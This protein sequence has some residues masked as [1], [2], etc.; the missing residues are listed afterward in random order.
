MRKMAQHGLREDF[1]S[2]KN[3]TMESDEAQ[4]GPW[5]QSMRELEAKAE[6]SVG[7]IEALAR[8]VEASRLFTA[9][10]ANMAI[11]PAEFISEATHGRGP[12]L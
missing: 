2:I 9:V 12:F 10:V 1:G 3:R 6:E 8:D 5:A 4:G 7:Q 11:A